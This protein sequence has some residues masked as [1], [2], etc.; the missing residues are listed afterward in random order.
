MSLNK[1]FP[2][3]IFISLILGISGENMKIQDNNLEITDYRINTQVKNTTN[4][5]CDLCQTIVKII[6]Y[7]LTV[8]NKSITEIETIVGDLCKILGNEKQKKECFD[9]LNIIND[10]AQMI[11]SG[12]D[13]KQ[14]CKNLDFCRSY[15]MMFVNITFYY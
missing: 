9:I 1:L 11:L 4:I 12:L 14:I 6:K 15:I 13:P 10:V 2:I 8:S 3:V 5:T 7:E